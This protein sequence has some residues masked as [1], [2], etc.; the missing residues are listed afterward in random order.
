M[1][2]QAGCQGGLEALGADAFVQDTEARRAECFV[3]AGRYKDALEVV[4]GVLEAAEGRPLVCAFLERLHGYALVQA[5]RAEEAA[6][7]SS[8]ASSWRAGS[9]PTTRLR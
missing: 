2:F 4:P 1:R 9:A 3:L 8:G 7:T 5:R 6:P